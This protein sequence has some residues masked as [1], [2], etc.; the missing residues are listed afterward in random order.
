GVG[1]ARANEQR[2][3]RRPVAQL[4]AA[5]FVVLAQALEGFGGNGGN[6][7]HHQVALGDTLRRQRRMR[8]QQ[9]NRKNHASH[10]FSSF[11]RIH[12]GA[13]FAPGTGRDVT[14]TAGTK[15]RESPMQVVETHPGNI[16]VIDTGYVKP[17]F[18]AAYL[19]VRGG[20]AAFFD[21]GVTRSLPRMMSA[22]EENNIPPEYVDYVFVSHVHLDHAGG[23]GAILQQLPNA[24][25]LVHPRGVDHLVSPGKLAASTIAVY[26]EK[27][28]RQLYGEVI[29][30]PQERIRAI[31][32]G[33]RIV[34]G[35]SVFDVLHTPGHALHH[36]CL[37]DRDANVLFTGDTFGISYRT[38]DTAKGAFI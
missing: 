18:D 33:E 38:F 13:A 37:H 19:I 27:K 8:Q 21:T 7:F 25:V 12:S 3:I 35:G 32:D 4:G 16:S 29:P 5:H 24:T 2:A 26:G 11:D 30:V 6:A 9:T 20:R 23:A 10:D 28:F 36:L 15:A 14:I 17:R 31:E 22:L 1:K 34:L